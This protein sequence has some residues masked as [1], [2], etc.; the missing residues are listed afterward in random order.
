MTSIF[1]N[2]CTYRII[3]MYYYYIYPLYY[4]KGKLFKRQLLKI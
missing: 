1:E 2:I 3:K 4:I